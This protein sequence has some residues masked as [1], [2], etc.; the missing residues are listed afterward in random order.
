MNKPI[1]KGTVR[2]IS[3]LDI[4]GP[5]LVKG[6]NLEGLRVLGKPEV[7]ARYYYEQGADELLYMDIVAS[8][9]QRNNLLDIVKRTSREVFIPLTV[10][11]GLRS[12]EDIRTTLRAG[13][14]KVALN[15]AAINEPEL[16]AKAARIFG[17][18]TIVVSVEAIKRPDGSYEAYTDNGR[19][20]TGKDAVAWAIEAARLGAGEILVTAIQNEGAGKGFDLSLTRKIASSVSVPVIACGGAGTPDD[21]LQV[22]HG[23]QADAV[24][25]AS[26]LHYYFVNNGNPWGDFSGE[27]NVEFLKNKGSFMRGKNFALREIKDYLAR[28]NVPCRPVAEGKVYA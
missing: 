24:C 18:S 6:V 7:F 15:T 3:R 13:A 28:N 20:S 19:Q 21:C 14:D 22:I 10:G 17:S 4:K 26:V 11:G 1:S 12:I 25:L 27:G 8:L 9:Y 23:G 2:I 5:N 16:I